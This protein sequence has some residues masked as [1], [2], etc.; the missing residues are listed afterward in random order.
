M[1]SS[2]FTASSVVPA[3]LPVMEPMEVASLIDPRQATQ[4]PVA[5]SGSLFPDLKI[6]DHTSSSESRPATPLPKDLLSYSG[7]CPDP[8]IRPILEALAQVCSRWFL[9]MK[10]AIGRER[11][12]QMYYKED[13]GIP[14]KA[15]IRYFPPTLTAEE[16][17]IVEASEALLRVMFNEETAQY[18]SNG[19]HNAVNTGDK[20]SFK[21]R[22]VMI[23]ARDSLKGSDLYDG[24]SAWLPHYIAKAE[25]DAGC[26]PYPGPRRLSKKEKERKMARMEYDPNQL[27]LPFPGFY[28]KEEESILI[29]NKNKPR[30]KKAATKTNTDIDDTAIHPKEGKES[31]SDKQ[32]IEKKTGDQNIPSSILQLKDERVFQRVISAVGDLLGQNTIEKIANQP[33]YQDKSSNTQTIETTPTVTVTKNISSENVTVQPKKRKKSCYSNA[34]VTLNSGSLPRKTKDYENAKEILKDIKAGK[35]NPYETSDEVLK[36]MKNGEITAAEA[37]LYLSLL[38]NIKLLRASKGRRGRKS[39]N[40]SVSDESLDR[41]ANEI[42]AGE[43]DEDNEDE[44]EYGEEPDDDEDKEGEDEDPDEGR[45]RSKYSYNPKGFDG[46]YSEGGYAGGGMEWSPDDNW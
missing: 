25:K 36:G 44:E 13:N 35:I 11:I 23:K 41:L 34:N 37:M 30:V 8:A 20:R 16:K 39:R 22:L 1:D 14:L 9:A 17:A 4:D 43:E 31:P 32:D 45:K 28:T 38:H 21:I 24:F 10:S 3:A 40:G 5:P 19:F 42:Q 12:Q 33:K 2:L 27:M 46:M 18:A 29:D 26:T 6:D 15:K 7:A